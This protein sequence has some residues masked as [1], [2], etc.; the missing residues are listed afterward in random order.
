MVAVPARRASPGGDEAAIA[1]VIGGS[2]RGL[3]T[4][5][6]RCPSEDPVASP[7]ASAPPLLAS[8]T[9]GPSRRAIVDFVERVTTPGHD[10]FVAA[11]E[12]IAGFDNA[13]PGGHG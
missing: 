7:P 5:R 4:A 2:S 6:T 1:G 9:D 11:V 10:D 8:W 13:G 12:R 3:R